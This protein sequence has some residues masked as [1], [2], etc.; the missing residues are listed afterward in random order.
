M[1]SFNLEIVSPEEQ[2]FSG[3]AQKLFVTGVMGELEILSGHAPLLTSLNP[4]PVWIVK[5]NGEEEGLV[6][7]GGMLAVQPDITIVLADA[8][9]RAK[10]IDEAAA[11]E[12]KI[13][14]EQAIFNRESGLDYVKARADLNLVLAQLRIVRKIQSLRK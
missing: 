14:T 2:L 12:A 9:L 3:Y 7:F 6:I 1:K 13:I 4:G 10:D 8:A 11:K 5:E